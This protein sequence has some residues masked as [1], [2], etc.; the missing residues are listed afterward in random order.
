MNHGCKSLRLVRTKCF[1]DRIENDVTTRAATNS[2][3]SSVAAELASIDSR[4]SAARTGNKQLCE[5]VLGSDEL[6]VSR[7]SDFSELPE[8]DAAE[9]VQQVLQQL[10]DEQMNRAV[11]RLK[12]RR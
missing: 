5:F 1:A 8:F 10:A 12:R 3:T 7:T 4:G 9:T 2:Y 11:Q 6:N